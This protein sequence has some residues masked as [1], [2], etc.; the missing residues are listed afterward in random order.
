MQL[1]RVVSRPRSRHVAYPPPC[2]A[3]TIPIAF[4][5]SHLVGLFSTSHSIV[6]V[7]LLFEAHKDLL[8]EFTYFLPDNTAPERAPARVRAIPPPSKPDA[9]PQTGA[10]DLHCCR[11]SIAAH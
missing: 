11:I 10:H 3:C 2:A 6:Q 5:P 1:Q 8:T 4:R 9:E 7:A